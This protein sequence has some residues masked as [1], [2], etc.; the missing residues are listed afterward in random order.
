MFKL[1]SKE[2]EFHCN[3][4]CQVVFDTLKEKISSAPVLRGPNWKFPFHI[5]TYAYDS[6]IGVVL[7]Q[8]ENIIT[9]AIYFVSKN[10]THVELNYT[11]TMKEFLAGN[12]F[13]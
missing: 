8:K 12:L 5:S 7:G 11:V 4:E 13:Y 1:L 9:H 6:A 3:D 10:L 2:F